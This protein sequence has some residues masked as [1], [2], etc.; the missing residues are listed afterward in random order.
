MTDARVLLAAAS[1]LALAGAARAT[2]YDAVADFSSASS[3]GIF[4]YGTGVTGSSFTPYPVLTPDCLGTG[5]ECWQ[6]TTPVLLVPLVAGNESGS[7]INFG[8]VVFP[9]NV[10]NVHPGPSTDSIVR[11]TAPTSGRYNISGFYELLDTNPSGVNVI[12]AA[13]GF[14]LSS[15]LLTGPGAMHPGTPGGSFAFAASNVFLPA[16]TIIDYGVN[17]AGS[18]FND[19]TGLSLTITSVPEPATW[20]LMLVGVGGLGAQLRGARRRTV[21]TAA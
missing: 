4:S 5:S 20:A 12:I 1:A 18:F 15:T 3:T 8:T 11:F 9:T 6:T 2:T 13:N 17:N 21:A 10:L 19:S 7:T 14:V 16:G